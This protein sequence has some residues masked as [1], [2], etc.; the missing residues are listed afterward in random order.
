MEK[1]RAGEITE[2]GE[3]TEGDIVDYNL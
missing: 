2:K 1:E 3:E